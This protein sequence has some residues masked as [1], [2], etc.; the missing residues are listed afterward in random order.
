MRTVEP[1]EKHATLGIVRAIFLERHGRPEVFRERRVDDPEVGRRDLKLRVV[2]AGVNFADLLQRL[3]LY[4]HAPRLPYIPGFEVAGEVI[5]CGAQVESFSRGDRVVALLPN[6]GYSDTVAVDESA[7]REIPPRITF[8]EAAAIPVNYLTAWFCLFKLG[9]LSE[10]ESVLIHSAAGG[11][12]VAAVQLALHRGGRI[13]ATTGS[14]EKLGFLRELGV[15]HAVLTSEPDWPD[16]IRRLSAPG[17]IDVVLES[18]GGECLQIS[19]DLLAPL[20]RLVF[21]GLSKAVP[22]PR[23]NWLKTFVAWWRTPRFSPLAMIDRSA[24]VSGF[25]LG[26]LDSKKEVVATAFDEI[27]SQVGTGILKP[28]VSETFPLTAAGAAKAHHFIHDRRN[29]G[30]VLLVND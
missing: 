15:E 20:G 14:Q 8:R 30:K 10:G 12:G 19:Y 27:L 16:R 18:V 9:F 21:F 3:G 4:G 11:V 13:Y 2:S 22:G 29:R 26:L 5:A 6:G 17:G 1:Q 24:A 7:A 23:R 28:V 25:H